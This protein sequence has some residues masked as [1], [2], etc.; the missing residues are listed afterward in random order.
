MRANTINASR[1]RKIMEVCMRRTFYDVKRC[2]GCG[3]SSITVYCAKCSRYAKC[4]HGGKVG[5]C[6][7]CDV[8]GD[9]A[10]DAGREK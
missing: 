5:E 1:I 4:P 10:Y 7:D 2:K 3:K 8:E 6:T 9:L